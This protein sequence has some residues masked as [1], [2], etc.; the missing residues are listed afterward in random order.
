[1][2]KLMLCIILSTL[3]INAYSQDTIC[4]YFTVK[5]VFEFDYLSSE[6]VSYD[7]QTT[8]FYTIK[9]VYRQVLCLD[10]SDEKKRY[11][12][13]ITTFPDGEKIT[14]ILDSQ[15]EVYYWGFGPYTIQVGRP[16]L[17]KI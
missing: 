1:M 7:L 3:F 14:Q 5:D 13:I 2:K 17:F 6:P 15:Q 16:T 4:T 8:K 9:L 11:R 10:L 12:K